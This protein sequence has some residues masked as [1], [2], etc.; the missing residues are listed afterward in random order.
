M[1]KTNTITVPCQHNSESAPL[2][3][4]YSHTEIMHCCTVPL[5]DLG[6]CKAAEGILRM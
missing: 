1:N 5:T 3:W 2:F 4:E 6:R